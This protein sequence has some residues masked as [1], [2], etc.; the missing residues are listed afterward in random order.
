MTDSLRATLVPVRDTM[1]VE[2]V[3]NL[4]DIIWRE[5]YVPII[6]EEQVN[7]MLKNLQSTE[8]MI[9][10]IASGKTEYF[11]I[12]AHNEEIGY[13]AI[14][15]QNQMMF[16]S[17]L[18]LLNSSRGNGFASQIIKELKIRALQQKKSFIQ[19][20]VN[21]YN[22]SAITF[23]EKMGFVKIDSIISSIGDGFVMDDYVYEYDLSSEQ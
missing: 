1:Q 6:G 2:D 18:Y 19:L 4:A 14:E 8:K 7:Y 15:W 3:A 22:S 20:T 12:E 11:S 21:K 23:Y 13:V 5:H 16:I 10:D 9:E 17:K